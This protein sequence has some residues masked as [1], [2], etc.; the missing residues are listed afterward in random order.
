MIEKNLVNFNILLP[1]IQSFIS[2]NYS[3]ISD[4]D[5]LK[6]YI[7]Q[8]IIAKNYYVE[9]YTIGP[10]VNKLYN[11]MAE[12]SFLSALLKRKDIEEININSWNDVEIKLSNGKS[13][14]SKEHFT[15]PEH[16]NDII[17]RI[18]HSQKKVFD[19]NKNIVTSFLGGNIR[20]TA[21]HKISC[22][23]KSGVAC[24]IRM[25]NPQKLDTQN[26]IDN[27]TC[28]INQHLFLSSLFTYGVSIV[29][30][31]A[32]GSGKTTIMA[33]IMD[34]YPT[35]KR[36]IT[37]EKD[38][39]EFDLVKTDADGNITNNVLHLVTVPSEDKEREITISK[40]LT[41]SLTMDPDAIC[42]AEMKNEEAWEAQEAART[43]HAVLTTTHA[44]SCHEV[45]TRLTTLCMQKYSHISFDIILSLN[46]QAFPISVYMQKLDTGE[47]KI[48]EIAE[49]V[50][51]YAN[52]TYKTNTLWRYDFHQEK[53]L[54][55]GII[56][57]SLQ[58]R[59]LN[60]GIPFDVFNKIINKE[61]I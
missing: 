6:N 41:A 1:E 49:S 52:K 9:G 5:M 8:Y 58:D 40:L 3:N 11:E 10:L 24:S 27:G 25:V 33:D 43:G 34:I 12:F 46:V 22:G 42:V 23:D 57:K 50:Y 47:R 44:N 26:L 7:K 15:S 55:T 45:Y 51:D 38:V 61:A 2:R 20:I 53:F 16:A 56:S 59:L 37:I 48:T 4:G 60:N 54:K 39:R 35:H 19:E 14:K 29:F 31:G 28:T 21:I 32:T 17:R 13:Y 30:A 36:L 18:F